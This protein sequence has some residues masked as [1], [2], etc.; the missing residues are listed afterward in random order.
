MPAS[1]MREFQQSS[2][3][4]TLVETAQSTAVGVTVA[5]LGIAPLTAPILIVVLAILTAIA[6]RRIGGVPLAT[7]NSGLRTHAGFA[8]LAFIGLAASSATWSSEPVFGFSSVVRVAITLLAAI[9]LTIAL[10]RQLHHMS[11]LHRNRFIRAI[12]IGAMIALVILFIETSSRNG[13]SSFLLQHLPKFWSG[14]SQL[15]SSGDESVSRLTSEPFMLNRGIAAM[16]IVSP[17]L[18]L[19]ISLWM[20]NRVTSWIVA[21]LAIWIAAIVFMSESETAKLAIVGGVIFYF[22]AW[23][24]PGGAW[25]TLSSVCIIGTVLALPLG[26]LPYG[27]G[28]HTWPSASFSAQERVLIWRNT[29]VSTLAR[30]LFGVGVQSTRFQNSDLP[31]IVSP[32]GKNRSPLG[33][34]AHNAF[35]Q[36]WFEL[37]AVGAGTLL[38][39]LLALIGSLRRLDASVHPAA[40]ATMAICILVASTGW[41]MW[42]PWLV[43]TLAIGTVFVGMLEAAIVPHSTDNPQ[44]TINQEG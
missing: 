10:R 18:M 5:L 20:K 6:E 8:G 12:P 29:A 34:H 24:R 17:A 44:Q 2:H 22:L 19:A 25:R 42:Q 41:S 23:K 26:V 32:S 43:A 16:V 39:V 1:D 11:E 38:M 28:V 7:L 9:Y 21:A 35:L 14:S 31:M 40:V 36:T 30:P 4:W 15:V 33:W 27:L 37:G 3:E 13:L